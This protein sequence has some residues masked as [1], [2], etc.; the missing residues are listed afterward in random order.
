MSLILQLA[1]P[2]YACSLNHD[3]AATFAACACASTK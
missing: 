1:W 3:S 2:Q